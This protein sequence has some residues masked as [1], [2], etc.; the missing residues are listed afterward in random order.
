M[1]TQH[2]NHVDETA[3]HA[4]EPAVGEPDNPEPQPVRKDSRTS[5]SKSRKNSSNLSDGDAK[6]NLQDEL[7]NQ[8]YDNAEVE[9]LGNK[10]NMLWTKP[11]DQDA[12]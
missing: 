5:D 8:N 6:G 10:S 9:R 3:D 1:D 11:T 12:K 4:D 2:N 7:T